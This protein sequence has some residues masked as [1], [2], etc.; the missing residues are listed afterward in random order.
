M[1][2]SFWSYSQ[3]SSHFYFH[4]FRRRWRPPS[5][6]RSLPRACW[7][8][9]GCW[10][11]R[12]FFWSKTNSLWRRSLRG[13][14]GDDE[15]GDSL[16]W[17]IPTTVCV[18]HKNGKAKDADGFA[19]YWARASSDPVAQYE[20][21]LRLGEKFWVVGVL[22]WKGYTLRDI[23]CLIFCFWIILCGVGWFSA[24]IIFL[25]FVPSNTKKYGFALGSSLV[26][27]KLC[28]K[29]TRQVAGLLSHVLR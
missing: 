10:V 28:R 11:E 27:L 7:L 12:R 1:E 4:V 16:W 15:E 21:P 3:T 6:G 9:C 14:P 26:D 18:A 25:S 8:V 5:W 29:L 19:Y 20:P 17:E 13:G 22:R 23:F 2:C 24:Y